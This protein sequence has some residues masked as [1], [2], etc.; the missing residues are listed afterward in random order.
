MKT[1]IPVIVSPRKNNAI[2]NVK[3]G[4]INLHEQIIFPFAYFSILYAR[5]E[6]INGQVNISDKKKELH[7]NLSDIIKYISSAKKKTNKY[8][9]GRV[10]RYTRKKY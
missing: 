7:S 4:Q 3:L 5:C 2:I 1:I 8:Q 9:S 10:F 6:W